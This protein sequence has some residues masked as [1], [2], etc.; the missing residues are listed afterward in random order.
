MNSKTRLTFFL[1]IMLTMFVLVA[2]IP[3]HAQKKPVLY[4]KV[5][6]Q[7]ATGS[8]TNLS[9]AEVQLLEI[10]RDQ[11]PGKVLY[12]TYTSNYGDFVFYKIAKGKY[13][14]KVI[15]NNKVFFQLQGNKKVE[16]NFV[17]VKEDF[18][19]MNLPDII[20]LR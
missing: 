12:Q 4:G 18:K 17:E 16:V 5:I 3:M 13:Y 1:T 8:K 10:T 6:F 2:S 7:T 15:Q 14:L 19:S 20:V 11:K 9:N